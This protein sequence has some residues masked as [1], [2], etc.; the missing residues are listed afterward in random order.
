MLLLISVVLI[1][2]LFVANTLLYK[3]TIVCL[4]ISV[5]HL[6]TFQFF[7]CFNHPTGYTILGIQNS[8]I[9]LKTPLSYPYKSN[10]TVNSPPVCDPWQPLM[11]L[12]RMFASAIIRYITFCYVFFSLSVMTLR[13]IQVVALFISFYC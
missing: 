4:V 1:F 10:Y 9:T 5:G 8:F 11:V 13:S 2:Y 12:I 3:Y 6:G 7:G